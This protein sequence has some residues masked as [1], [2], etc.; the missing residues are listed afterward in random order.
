[1]TI[2]IALVLPASAAERIALVIGNNDYQHSPL[3]NPINDASDVSTKLE[4]YGFEV[5]LL[6]NVDRREFTDAIREFSRKL[7]G[8]NKVGLFF[9]AGHAVELDGQNYL[10][11]VNADIQAENDVQYETINAQ[12][13]LTAMENAGNG[14]NLVILDACRNNPFRGFFRGQSRGIRLMSAPRGSLIMYSAQPGEVAEDGRGRN[15][16]FTKHLLAQLERQELEVFDVFRRTAQSVYGETAGRQL[17]YIEGVLLSDF[18]FHPDRIR[19]AKINPGGQATASEFDIPR[20]LKVCQSH[21]HA[22]RLTSPSGNNAWQCYGAVLDADP[23]NESAVEGLGRVEKRYVAL[24]Q[25][26]DN[27]GDEQKTER[28]RQILFD[29]NPDNVLLAEIQESSR[30]ANGNGTVQND[31]IEAT[32]EQ[33]ASLTAYPDTQDRIETNLPDAAH[34]FN[35]IWQGLMSCSRSSDGSSAFSRHVSFRINGESV[36]LEGDWAMGDGVQTGRISLEGS[37]FRK[38]GRITISGTDLHKDGW[39][40]KY[41]YSGVHDETISLKGSRGSRDCTIDLHSKL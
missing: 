16:T 19:L 1:M 37:F 5:T 7:T 38:K 35:G 36:Q 11:P 27:S 12:R 31:D 6:K 13:I 40:M 22:N 39:K 33:V 26:A 3:S 8:E 15:G 32:V 23:G 30:A 34:P 9:Y 29:L 14:L 21:L 17:P 4:T 18:Y 28:Y 2:F 10:I 41:S 20:V 24:Y 25:E